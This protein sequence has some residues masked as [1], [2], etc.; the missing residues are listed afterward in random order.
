MANLD[1]PTLV[2]DLSSLS[3]KCSMKLVCKVCDLQFSPDNLFVIMCFG[4]T[5]PAVYSLSDG[6][7]VR[8][9]ADFGQVDKVLFSPDGRYFAMQ[10]QGCG[11]VVYLYEK[12]QFVSGYRR[13][14]ANVSK[15][16]WSEDSV[17]IAIGFEDGWVYNAK[18]NELY[19]F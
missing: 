2:Y 13:E 17:R 15:L 18:V 11:V 12:W 5:G 6:K 4:Y 16:A 7:M 9:I 10:G 1:I 8:K 3:A 19:S 14:A